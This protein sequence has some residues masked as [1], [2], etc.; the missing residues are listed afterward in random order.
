MLKNFNYQPVIKRANL[1]FSPTN[2]SIVGLLAL[3]ILGLLACQQAPAPYPRPI[4]YPRI[5]LPTN[6]SYERFSNNICPFTFAYPTFGDITRSS[7]DSC[8]VDIYFP[9]YECTWHITYR[10]AQKSGKDRYVH[11]EEHRGLIFKHSKQANHIQTSEITGSNGYGIFY[12]VYGNVGTPA[13]FFYSDSTDQQ[14][15]MTSFYFDYALK[16]DSLRPVVDYMKS[17][18]AHMITSIEWK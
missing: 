11:L 1:K 8:W 16:N 2:I 4:G 15:V 10:D 12:E 3:P 6:T 17:Q 14:I 13:Q 9:S 7:K 5:E 18:L